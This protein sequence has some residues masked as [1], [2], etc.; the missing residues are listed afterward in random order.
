MVSHILWIVPLAAQVP[1]FWFDTSHQKT[2]KLAKKLQV[3]PEK[4]AKGY[5]VVSALDVRAQVLSIYDRRNGV[6]K[7]VFKLAPPE[8]ELLFDV[9]ALNLCEPNISDVVLQQIVSEASTL[10]QVREVNV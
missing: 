4:D 10:A 5:F 2:E 1:L 7:P 6:G 8:H 3:V 9:T